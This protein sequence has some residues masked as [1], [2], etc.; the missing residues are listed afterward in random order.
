MKI[1]QNFAPAAAD[2]NLIVDLTPSE[3]AEAVSSYLAKRGVNVEGKLLIEQNGRAIT[4]ATIENTVATTANVVPLPVQRPDFYYV[5]THKK[6]EP[7]RV[8]IDQEVAQAHGDIG[9]FLDIFDTNGRPVS[10]WKLINNNTPG[11]RCWTPNF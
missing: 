1:T 9:S 2:F 4:K 11:V 7:L 5:L 3:L 8:F 6:S 10:T